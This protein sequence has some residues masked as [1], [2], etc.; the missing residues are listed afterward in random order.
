MGG[1]GRGGRIFPIFPLVQFSAPLSRLNLYN[2]YNCFVCT[3]PSATFNW[4]FLPQTACF[5]CHSAHVSLPVVVDLT[6]MRT[7][8]SDRDT[9]WM[10]SQPHVFSTKQISISVLNSVSLKFP[11]RRGSHVLFQKMTWIASSSEFPRDSSLMHLRSLDV[12]LHCLHFFFPVILIFQFPTWMSLT[13]CLQ[14][15]RVFLL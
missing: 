7:V 11:G 15:S 13:L 9:A 5:S 14:H 8:S 12:G 4:Q 1:G 2:G 6:W 3:C 10:L